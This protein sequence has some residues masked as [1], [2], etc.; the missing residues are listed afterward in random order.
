METFNFP[1]HEFEEE[2]PET[3]SGM[4]FGNSYEY[5][6]AAVA[7]PTLNITL[8]MT[9]MRYYYDG[10]VLN[11]SV[12]PTTNIRVLDAFYL[13]HQLSEK[14]IYPH[15]VRGNLNC[16]FAAPLNIPKVIRGSPAILPDFSIKLI[17]LP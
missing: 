14:F 8:T 15:P 3:G 16:R 17:Y 10:N 6:S 13:A 11:S 12:N 5:R 7:P 9:G 4:K 1:F 2:Y